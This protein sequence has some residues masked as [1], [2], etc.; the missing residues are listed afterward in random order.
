MWKR[1]FPTGQSL[2][3]IQNLAI[4]QITSKIEESLNNLSDEIRDKCIIEIKNKQNE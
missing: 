3:S 4:G 1:N 2:P